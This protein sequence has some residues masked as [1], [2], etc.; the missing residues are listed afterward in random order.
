MNAFDSAK[1]LCRP[2]TDDQG[3]HSGTTA[4]LCLLRGDKL[5]VANAGDSRCVLSNKGL[6]F[7]VKCSDSYMYLIEIR[8]DIKHVRFLMLYIASTCSA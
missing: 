3:Y 6:W 5:V 8:R 4:V 7:Y 1:R 2:V